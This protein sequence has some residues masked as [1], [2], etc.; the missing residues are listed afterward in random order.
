MN[1]QQKHYLGMAISAGVLLCVML[2]LWV[3]SM[4]TFFGIYIPEEMVG[5]ISGWLWVGLIVLAFKLHRQ[6][7]NPEPEKVIRSILGF[8]SFALFVIGLRFVAIEFH[9]FPNM[10]NNGFTV[11]G[12][13]MMLFSGLIA[14]YLLGTQEK[15]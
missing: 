8:V 6:R 9:I 2:A 4:K 13:F 12:G 7:K 10:A 11:T 5:D 3:N 14:G 15:K 1:K